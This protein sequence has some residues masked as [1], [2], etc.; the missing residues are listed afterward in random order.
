MAGACRLYW[1]VVRGRVSGAVVLVAASSFLAATPANPKKPDAAALSRTT[2]SSCHAMAAPE[3]LP[4][5]SWRSEIEKMMLIAQ[6][7]GLSSWGAPLPPV[8]LSPEYEEI[9]AYYESRAPAALPAPERWPAPD[10]RLR[11]ERRGFSPEDAHPDPAVANVRFASLDRASGP[12]LDL[13]VCDMRY[14]LVLRGRP[15][16]P[17]GRLEPMAQVPHPVHAEVVDLD[18]DGVRDV[19]VADLGE[20]FPSDH[21]RGAVVWLRGRRDG[22]FD[23]YSFGGFPRVADVEAADFEGTGRLDLVVAAFGWFKKGGIELLR[24][25][26][27]GGEPTFDRTPLDPR[28]GAIHVVPVDLD[29]DGLM[30]F[31]ALISQQHETAVAF[32]NQGQGRGFRAET[33]YAAPHPNW[34]SSGIQVV[35]FDGD[36]DMDVLMTNGDMFDDRL[37]KPY[38]G[39]QWLENQGRYPFKPHLLAHLPGVHRALAVDLDGDGDLDV[40]ACVFTAGPVGAAEAQLPSLVWLEQVRKGVFDRHTLEVGKLDHAT[41]DAA[42]FDRDG[43]VDLVVGNF[44]MGP[45]LKD[46][47]E[48]WENQSAHR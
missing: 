48:L 44:S 3:V 18:G 39:I 25:G 41:L 10:G 33:I 47:V 14:G 32:L 46:F 42:D 20:F 13:I 2:C 24:R 21:E 31:V 37:L 45:A 36:G 19:V 35:D 16:D 6:G 22:G 38:H 5:S 40:V 9:L 15:S 11:F 4:R 8:A 43:D 7:K 23:N 27:S 34:G 1:R 29:R 28:A 26:P 12:D 17:R 30:D